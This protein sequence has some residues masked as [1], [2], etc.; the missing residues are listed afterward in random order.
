MRHL[1]PDDDQDGFSD[2]GVCW[3][4]N[5][6]QHITLEQYREAAA[7]VRQ[8]TE[9]QPAIGLI[10]GSGLG[11][12]VNEIESQDIIPYSEITHWPTSTVVGHAG[13]LVI[14]QM[15]GHTV[16][17]MQGR[18]HSYEGYSMAQVTLPV[19]V[20]Q[21]LGIKTLIVTNAAGGLNPNFEAGDIMVIED[22]IFPGGMAGLNPL[23]G[24]NIPE[25]GPRFSIH[26]RSYDPTLRK[27]AH[28]VAREHQITLREGV[29]VSL[30]GPSFETPAE[31][32]ML[33]A[34]GGDAVGM[35]TAPEVL[36]ANHAGMRVLGFSSITNLSLDNTETQDDISHEE[37]L[38]LGQLIVPRLVTLIRGVLIDMPPYDP[39][40][41][42]NHP[43]C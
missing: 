40:S 24:P 4:M 37:V 11:P 32:R 25:F 13:R 6:P 18:V 15:S 27:L 41:V 12:F 31:V 16:L 36:V 39:G 22:H 5:I 33:R 1:V 3:L 28:K 21:I 14:G 29:Y 30:S 19:R 35:S 38:R 17:A 7:A 2:S 20:M 8:R 23:R 26:T 34:W 42:E 10:L 43:E 9:Q